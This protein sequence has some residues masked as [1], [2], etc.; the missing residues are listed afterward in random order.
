MKRYAKAGWSLVWGFAATLQF[1]ALAGEDGDGP[2]DEEADASTVVVARGIPEDPLDALRVVDVIDSRQLSERRPR[3][4]PEALMEGAG[5]YI[6]KTNHAGGSPIIRGMVGPQNL[7]LIDGVRFNNSTYRTGPLQYLNTVDSFSLERIELMRGPGSVLYGS[8]A[9]GGVIDLVTRDPVAPEEGKTSR[10]APLVILRGE[11][12]DLERSGRGALSFDAKDFGLIG[13]ASIHVFDDLRAG[14]DLGVQ[15]WSGYDEVDWDAKVRV[16]RAG[17]DRLEILY[18]GVRVRNAG[19]T[20]KLESKGQLTLYDENFRDLVY[21]A[22]HLRIDPLATRITITPSWQRQLETRRKI[23]FSDPEYEDVS[24][25]AWSRDTVNTLG[26]AV[27]LD[28]RLFAR[29][30]DLVYGAEYY[31]DFVH[32]EA[33][34]GPD[35]ASMEE[36]IPTY[37]EGSGYDTFGA[38]ALATGTPLRTENWVEVVVYAGARFSAFAA[39]APGIEGFGDVELRSTGGVAAAGI[40]LRKRGVFNVG[41]GFD[42]GFR[43]PNLMESARIGD[44]GNWFHVP[45]PALNSERAESLEASGRVRAGPVALGA[46]VYTTFLRDYIV[47]LPATYEGNETVGGAMVVQNAN[48]GRGRVVG[49]EGTLMV[50]TPIGVAVGGNLTWTH[51][52]YEDPVEGWVPMS[53]IPPLFGNA[54]VRVARPWHDLFVEVFAQFAGAQDRLSPLDITDP[55]IPEDGTP[56]WWTL[57]LRAGIRPVEWLQISVGGS[58]LTNQPYKVH[59]SGIYGSGATAWLALEVLEG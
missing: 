30:L 13:G 28:T 10:F 32:S 15:P 7:I 40:H 12:C 38:Y 47:R 48:S 45:N 27:R 14:G 16:G 19:R 2:E 55:R 46:V 44:T 29:R 24:K 42:E 35:E 22:G 39:R 18:Q 25:V 52:E 3:T 17:D 5:A 34:Q 23:S 41:I 58:N 49:T 21:A 36:A 8:D 33:S 31:H 11:T 6:Q 43:A 53:R 37:P 26:G 59:G 9:I 4:V 51:G 1:P 54:R 50:E 56:G 20:D 57:N